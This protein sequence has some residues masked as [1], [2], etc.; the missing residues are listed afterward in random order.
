MCGES[1]QK[2]SNAFALQTF[3]ASIN[4]TCYATKVKMYILTTTTQ[5]EKENEKKK[6][7]HLTLTDCTDSLYIFCFSQFLF[8]FS[9]EN[10]HQNKFLVHFQ[11]EIQ[12]AIVHTQWRCSI[13][14]FFALHF[15]EKKNLIFFFSTCLF[16]SDSVCVMFFSAAKN[17]IFFFCSFEKPSSSSQIKM[18]SH[19]AHAILSYIVYLLFFFLAAHT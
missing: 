10:F 17:P 13:C 8:F 16:S 1:I 14:V 12:F 18:L 15:N 11:N 5:N 2:C 9:L 3:T 4:Y 7:L 6:R 19:Y